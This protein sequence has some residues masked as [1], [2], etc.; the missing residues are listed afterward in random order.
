M[1]RTLVV[2]MIAC[3]SLLSGCIVYTPGGYTGVYYPVPYGGYRR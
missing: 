3:I 1:I 2:S